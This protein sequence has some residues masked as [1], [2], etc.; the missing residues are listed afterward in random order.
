MHQSFKT[1]SIKIAEGHVSL[2]AGVVLDILVGRI[3]DPDRFSTISQLDGM[4]AGQPKIIPLQKCDE[5]EAVSYATTL[6]Q[7][8]R[9]FIWN[10]PETTD[11]HGLVCYS[12]NGFLLFAVDFG[13]IR[14]SIEGAFSVTIPEKLVY[15][16][17]VVSG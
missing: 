13:G 12:S 6:E 11:I 9:T 5:Y 16:R 8:D 10:I 3:D 1:A 2:A 17:Q 7:R 4:V 14:N 15:F